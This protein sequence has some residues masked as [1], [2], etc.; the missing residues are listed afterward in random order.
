MIFHALSLS[1]L[2]CLEKFEEHYQHSSDNLTRIELE[3]IKRC[4]YRVVLVAGDEL[5]LSGEQPAVVDEKTLLALSNAWRSICGVTN[6]PQVVQKN[7]WQ[8]ID[9]ISEG[10]LLPS[11][12]S[13]ILRRFQQLED[14][15]LFII[16]LT[17]NELHGLPAYELLMLC[18]FWQLSLGFFHLHACGVQHNRYLYLFTGP[19]DAGKSTVAALSRSAGDQVIDEDQVLVHSLAGGGY[20]ADGW[21]YGIVPCE[22]PLRAIFRLV[23]DS[24]DK[25]IPLNDMQVARL[26]L[27]RQSDILGG[28]LFDDLLR[29]SFHFASEIARQVP[30]YDLHFRKSPDFW[31]LI[32][33]EFPD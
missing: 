26:I 10:V 20:S 22:A 31:K 23:Q 9:R 11:H 24:E 30:G 15:D 28:M 3:K 25:L 19:S 16:L 6:R 5:V 27:E 2:K 4:G 14:E 21:G 29:K 13:F 1:A 18:D 12:R 32:D 17:G 33:E 8:V 7:S